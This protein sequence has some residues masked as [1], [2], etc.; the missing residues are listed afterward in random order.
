MN[1][2]SKPSGSRA[3]NASN[4]R[5]SKYR[6]TARCICAYL[7]EVASHHGNV[8]LAL[9]RGQR[10][11]SL[12]D[13][14]GKRLFTILLGKRPAAFE[15]WAEYKL[16]VERRNAAAHDGLR[17]TADQAEASIAIVVALVRFVEEASQ[18]AID[19]LRD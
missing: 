14:A 4:S 13:E 18:S 6:R 10:S 11:W 17:V 3:S 2:C 9:T 1:T 7:E 15:R 16:H 8:V 12:Q 5:S 19:G